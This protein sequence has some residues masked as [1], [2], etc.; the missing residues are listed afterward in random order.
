M[1]IKMFYNKLRKY[2]YL[3]YIIIYIYKY[4][5]VLATLYI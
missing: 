5:Y 1:K 3:I 4:I 2:L